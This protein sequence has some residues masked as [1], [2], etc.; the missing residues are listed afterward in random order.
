MDKKIRIVTHNASFHADDVFAVATLIIF[1]KDKEY[2][3]LRTRDKEIIESAD[4]VV[5]VGEVYDAEKNRFDHHQEGRA[6]KRENGIP[7]ASFGLVWK[8]FGVD[9]CQ[10]SNVAKKIDEIL[11]QSIDSRDNGIEIVDT[12]VQGVYPYTIGQIIHS[13]VPNYKEE[14]ANID[15]FFFKALDL[16]LVILKREIKVNKDTEEAQMILQNIY[17]SSKDNQIFV[18]DKRLPWGEFVSKNKEVIF[19][20]SPKRNGSWAIETA[21]DDLNSFEN[22]KSLPKKWGGK[23][24]SGL[25]EVTGVEDAIFCHTGLFI[26]FAESKEGALKLA[27]LALEN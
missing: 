22:R 7:Y 16:A 10:S 27:K 19:I 12:K 9:I 4:Y 26:A 21:R 13:F 8:K 11:V 1:L 17:N 24:D 15:D 25:V 20:V 3:I 5:D 6:G 14:D 23:R 2:E 18:L